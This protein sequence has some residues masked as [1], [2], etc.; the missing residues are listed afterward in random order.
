MN[1]KCIHKF[2]IGRT[3]LYEIF[4][5]ELKMGVSK[6]ILRRRLH[7]AKRLLKTTDMSISEI[8]HSVGFSDYNYFSRVYK[9]NYGK[10][11]RYYRQ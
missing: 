2:D 5:S 11:P 8:A 1:L 10:S 4:K 6:Y 7:R 3:R 9:K